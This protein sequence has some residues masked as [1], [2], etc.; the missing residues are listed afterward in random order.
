MTK[1]DLEIWRTQSNGEEGTPHIPLSSREEAWMGR[2]KEHYSLFMSFNFTTQVHQIK[3]EKDMKKLNS[4]KFK[5]K[6]Q[7]TKTKFKNK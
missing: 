4:K 6:N 1:K 3:K 5:F 2:N 7:I